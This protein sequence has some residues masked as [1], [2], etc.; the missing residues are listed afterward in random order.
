MNLKNSKFSYKKSIFFN[1][2]KP[3]SLCIQHPE[4]VLGWWLFWEEDDDCLEGR[5]NHMVT[6][7]RQFIEGSVHFLTTIFIFTFNKCHSWPTNFL[8]QHSH[9][10]QAAFCTCL[11]FVNFVFIL[12]TSSY[13]GAI[14]NLW[15]VVMVLFLKLIHGY[16]SLIL[17]IG[18]LTFGNVNLKSNET[19]IYGRRRSLSTTPEIKKIKIEIEEQFKRWYYST[20][21]NT[22]NGL[23][24]SKERI[25]YL[26]EVS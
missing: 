15:N 6:L 12:F 2:Q 24:N 19:D 21:I 3:V 22:A 9:W 11:Q 16:A 7:V 25:E 8:F 23:W 13:F 14:I 17:E 20:W 18:I 5:G 10:L 26:E 1:L 4:K